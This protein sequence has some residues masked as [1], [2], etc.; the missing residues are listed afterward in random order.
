MRVATEL[1]RVCS[2][3]LK[4]YDLRLFFVQFDV[5]I[6]NVNVTVT[7]TYKRVYAPSAI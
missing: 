4:F 5:C 2:I 1:T 3:L 7:S 6:H